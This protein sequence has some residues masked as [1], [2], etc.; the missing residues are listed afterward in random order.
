MAD[1]WWPTPLAHMAGEDPW[2]HDNVVVAEVKSFDEQPH[3]G[4]RRIFAALVPLDQ[5]KVVQAAFANLDHD[6][7]ASGPR[8]FYQ[9]D[10]PF[11]PDFWAGAKGLPSE[12]YEPL[13]L[14]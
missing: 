14:A 3:A 12:K 5:I 4:H 13:I 11:K 1:N 6:V 10:R 2:A 9:E 8:P 7:S